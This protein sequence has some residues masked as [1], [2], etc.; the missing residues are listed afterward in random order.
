MFL[1]LNGNFAKIMSREI[2]IFTCAVREGAVDM[3]G[4]VTFSGFDV[5]I[6]G[7][8]ASFKSAHTHTHTHTHTNTHKHTERERCKKKNPCFQVFHAVAA[9]ALPQHTLSHSD[10]KYHFANFFFFCFVYFGCFSLFR[11]NLSFKARRH[12]FLSGNNMS[13][14]DT[15]ACLCVCLQMRRW[16][17]CVFV[18]L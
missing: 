13:W 11:V 9:V 7:K 14:R 16:T 3:R 15:A 6:K 18:L 1:I 8:G 12:F 2:F 10:I 17:S 5:N 4:A